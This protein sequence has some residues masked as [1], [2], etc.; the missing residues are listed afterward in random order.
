MLHLL[1]KWEERCVALLE[2]WLPPC[3]RS[4]RKYQRLLRY[5]IS[6]GTAAAVDLVVLYIL[7]DIFKV[8]YLLSAIFA[9]LV[10]FLVSFVLQKFWTFQDRS[11]ERMHAQAAV[12]FVVAAVNLV[13]NTLFLYVFVDIFHM[14]YIAAQVVASGLIACES[15]FVSRYLIF[16]QSKQ[17][18][19]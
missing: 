19:Q 3:G 15:F 5:L 10:A 14:W 4:V 2:R 8:H 18:N 9:F 13:L 17:Q 12:Y 16:R 11:T 1:D 6:G 7:T